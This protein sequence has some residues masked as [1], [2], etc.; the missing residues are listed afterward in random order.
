MP[1]GKLNLKD[2]EMRTVQAKKA[3]GGVERCNASRCQKGL[4]WQEC[5]LGAKSDGK[6]A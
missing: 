2:K 1:N 3:R 4:I 5:S 6:C